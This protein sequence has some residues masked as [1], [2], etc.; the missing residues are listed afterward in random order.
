[1]KAHRTINSVTTVVMKEADKGSA[2]VVCDRQYNVKKAE[3]QLSN[4]TIYKEVE[5]EF[6]NGLHG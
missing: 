5:S 6:I 4:I 1:M 3:S 2:V